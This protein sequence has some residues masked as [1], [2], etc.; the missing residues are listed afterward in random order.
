MRRPVPAASGAPGIA[1]DER[2]RFETLVADLSVGF[3]GVAPE[4]V[5]AAIESAQR[6]VCECLD[7]DRFTLW[8]PDPADPA[9]LL[10]THLYQRAPAQPPADAPVQIERPPRGASSRAVFPWLLREIGRGEPVIIPDADALPAAAAVDR[11]SF[12]RFGYR[13]AAVVPLLDPGG[14]VGVLT[15]VSTSGTHHWDP[16]LVR[17]LAVIGRL[18]TTSL[19]RLHSEAALRRS[20]ARLAAAVNLAKLGFYDTVLGSD[21]RVFV[22]DRLRDMIGAPAVAP[23]EIFASWEAHLHPEDRDAVLGLRAGLWSG[24]ADTVSPEYRYFHPERGVIWLSHVASAVERDGSG[25]AVRLLGVIRDITESRR[26][27]QALAD[28]LRFETLLS[29]LSARFVRIPPGEVDAAIEDAQRR[30]CACLDLD[31]SALWQWSDDNPGSQVLTHIYRR[32]AGPPV[33][34]Q[35]DAREHFPWCLAEL[36]AGRPVI[37]TSVD[38]APPAAARDLEVWRRYG[39][40]S[41]LTIPL[42]SG[43][44]PTSGSLG[45]NTTGGEHPWPETL[46]Q[47]IRLVAEV[48]A[49]ALGRKRAEERLQ[50]STAEVK[51]LQELLE[52]ENRFLREEYRLKFGHGRIV[53]ESRAIA[54]VLA[55]VEQVAPQRSTVLLEGETGVGKELVARR[56]HELSP[57]AARPLVKVNCAGLPST[58]VESELFGREKGAF[59]GAVSREAGRFE[60]AHG[61]TILLDEVGELPLELQAKLLRVLE[62]GEFER[63]GSSRTLRTDA[64]VVAATNRDLAA[65]VA[66]GR[67]RRDLYYRLSAFPIRVP[68][69]R[70]RRE[71]IPLLMWAIIEEFA[72]AMHKEVKAVPRRTVEALKLYDWPGNV[73]ELRNVVER[74]MIRANGPT[75]V[76]E[77]PGAGP[78]GREPGSS[79]DEAQRH[80]IEKVLETAGGRISGPGGAAEL[81]GLKRTTLN[82]LMK[83]L[84]IERRAA[85]GRR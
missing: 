26:D 16:A 74:A 13:A 21:L 20:T 19:A 3:G 61:S 77:V 39:V 25:R 73:R 40:R 69:L 50:Q 30:I 66:A 38:A 47:R 12:R 34:R 60:V 42:S 8:Q 27:R 76:I 32:D 59:T 1:A 2:L 54:D 35:M 67:F 68:P 45:F 37:L 11:A 75:L 71:D 48:F 53:G 51:R 46:V 49:N 58:L 55:A 17:R 80:H 14:L 85:P 31:L 82:S 56:I 24:S 23:E 9:D 57:R 6:A 44:G 70:E 78:A 81:L 10:L 5:D 18:F 29:E 65:E 4:Q 7:L 83:R 84:G 36:A 22:D 72:A 41:A 33:P 79:L 43:G 62:E 52:F 64:R 63:V 28:Q 15:L